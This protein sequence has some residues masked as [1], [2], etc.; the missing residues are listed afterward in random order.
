MTNSEQLANDIKQHLQTGGVVRFATCY[1]VM[2]LTRKHAALVI[3]SKSPTD[4]GVYVR[5]GKAKTFWMA[6]NIKFSNEEI[7]R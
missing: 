5:S 2:D 6:Y 4:N 7:N 3:G 1:R